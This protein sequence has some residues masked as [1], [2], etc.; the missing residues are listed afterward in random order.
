MAWVN[1]GI[2]GYTLSGL[3]LIPV[4]GFTHEPMGFLVK[5]SPAL[6]KTAKY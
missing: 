2:F 6:S 3:L 4:M 5:M 1:L